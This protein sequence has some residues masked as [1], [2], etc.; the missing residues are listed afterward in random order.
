MK[1]A[2]KKIQSPKSSPIVTNNE[3]KT[4]KEFKSEDARLLHLKEVKEFNRFL[5]ASCDCV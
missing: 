1:P 3:T 2:I 4:S 5:E